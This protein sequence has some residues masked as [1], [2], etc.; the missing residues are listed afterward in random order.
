M[1]KVKFTTLC[2]LSYYSPSHIFNYLLYPCTGYQN[3]KLVN[4]ISS[5]YSI[6]LVIKTIHLFVA[7]KPKK[8]LM[9]TH[10]EINK[11]KFY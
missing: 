3:Y 8:D 6:S 4:N 10:F 7:M 2:E 5:F 9:N 1:L 11:R